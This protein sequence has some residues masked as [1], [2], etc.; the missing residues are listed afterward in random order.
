M[1]PASETEAGVDLIHSRHL[2][3]PRYHCDD[4]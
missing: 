3:F 4:A 2:H 1:T